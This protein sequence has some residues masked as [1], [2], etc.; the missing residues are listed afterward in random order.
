MCNTHERAHRCKRFFAV[1]T[2]YYHLISNVKSY[3][4]I[5]Q[6]L[7]FCTSH[8]ARSYHVA[9]QNKPVYHS[10]SYQLTLKSSYPIRL[11]F[12]HLS[13]PLALAFGGTG[14]SSTKG[15]SVPNRGILHSWAQDFCDLL[16]WIEV[17]LNRNPAKK[18]G[19]LGQ[20]CCSFT[21]NI[22]RHTGDFTPDIYGL[23]F[24]AWLYLQSFRRYMPSWY[25]IFPWKRDVSFPDI[26]VN[27]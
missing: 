26:L 13:S 24:W 25:V 4:I 5:S 21:R 2:S 11:L 12:N 14:R 15:S 16:T 3:P 1:I 6:I 10:I 18:T 23:G 27:G 7:I 9:H 8:S 17:I 19:K 22:F 20:D